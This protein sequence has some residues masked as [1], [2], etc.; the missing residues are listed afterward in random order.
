MNSPGI[1]RAYFRLSAIRARV[2]VDEGCAGRTRDGTPARLE[3]DPLLDVSSVSEESR[4]PIPL[5][6]STNPESSPSASALQTHR[7]LTGSTQERSNLDNL[8]DSE[9]TMRPISTM[10][11]FARTTVHEI[12]RLSTISARSVSTS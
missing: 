7:A 6:I 2:I 10:R 4:H 1:F 3:E 12:L 11:S 9:K 8:I 5:A